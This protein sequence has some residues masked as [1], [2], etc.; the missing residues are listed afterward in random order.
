[1]SLL[2]DVPAG[3]TPSTAALVDA[4]RSIS[5]RLAAEETT[6][7]QARSLSSRSVEAMTQ[8]GLWRI[9]TPRTFGGW[10]AG[11]RAQAETLFVTS[12]ADSA[13]GWV[14]MVINAHAWVAAN[15]DPDCQDEVF[16]GGPDTRIPGTLASQGRATKVDGG[17]ELN[18]RWQFAS[19]VDHGEWLLLGASTDAPER[20]VHSMVPKNDLVVDDTWFTL[21]LHGTGSKD[22]VCDGV[23]VPEHRVMPTKILFDGDSPHGDRHPTHFNRLPVTT[24][25]SIQLAAAVVGIADGGLSLFIERTSAQREI[26]LGTKRAD[27]P[28]TQMRVAESL[29]ELDAARLVVLAAADRCDEVARTG[30]QLTLE[31]RAQNKW[32]AA[33][34]VELCRRAVDRTFAAAGAHSIYD[35]SSIQKRARDVMTASHHAIADFD[36]SAEMFGRVSLGMSP[37]TPLL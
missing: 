3:S 4:A 36:S 13:A 23:F 5:D 34:A 18:G 31:E 12:A 17:W 1:M 29:A 8:A 25:L 15:F 22:L 16:A 27:R 30:V 26:Y 9:L 19:G 7:D 10:E 32:R 24:C 37:G 35:D 21:G 20:A 33:Y 28:G 2:T 6:S 11:L 14:Q